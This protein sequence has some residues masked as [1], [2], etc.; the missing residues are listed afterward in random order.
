MVS[1]ATGIMIIFVVCLATYIYHQQSASSAPNQANVK[2]N[3]FPA[4]GNNGITY[5][6]G[7]GG[8]NWVDNSPTPSP[9]G[10]D[11]SSPSPSPTTNPNV[12]FDIFTSLSDTQEV[13][14]V[15]W[16]TIN[17][18]SITE[19]DIYLKNTSPAATTLT[20]FYGSTSNWSPADAANYLN[21]YMVYVLVNGTEVNNLPSPLSH[22]QQVHARLCLQVDSNVTGVTNFSFQI[23]LTAVY[24]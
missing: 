16:G 6:P 4:T 14:S 23:T 10:N 24:A 9:S 8:L 19:H 5:Y 20:S 22:G 2:K 11:T 1:K 15:S 17:P 21:V 12:S 18:G 7:G 13:T 3:Y